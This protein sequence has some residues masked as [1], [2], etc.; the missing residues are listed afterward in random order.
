MSMMV[1]AIQAIEWCTRLLAVYVLIDSAEKLYNHRAF[2]PGGF[3]GWA[4]LRQHLFFASRPLPVRR[5]L[6]VLFDFRGWM[7]LLLL[8]GLSGIALLTLPHHPVF[9]TAGLLIVF[10][11]GSLVN[12]RQAPFGAETENRFA[13]ALTGALLLRSL[14]PTQLV[15]EVCLLFIALYTCVS[16]VT[17]GVT[18]WVDPA[19]RKGEGLLEVIHSPDLV[20]L[21]RLAAFFRRY[22]GAGRA[23]AWAT[24]GI[25]CLFPLALVAGPPFF[26]LFL[27]WGIVFHLT[28]AVVLRLGK[29]FWVWVATYPAIIFIAQ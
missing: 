23:L 19:W 5:L 24:I 21:E 7:A 15:T 29:F 22:P 14:V 3:F 28:I 10:V 26:W 6:D 25:E 1:T 17:A 16:Y 2:R 9:G 8:R 18:K 20:P 13:L 12:F 11:A 27:I 4:A